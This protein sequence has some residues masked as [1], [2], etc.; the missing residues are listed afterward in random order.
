MRS[1]ILAG[2]AAM[3]LTAPA[4]AQPSKGNNGGSKGGGNAPAKVE[5]GSGGGQAQRAERQ[6][7]RGLERQEARA[8]RQ[9]DRAPKQR[10][11]RAARSK[12]IDRRHVREERREDRGQQQREVRVD[13]D[14]REGRDAVVR[15]QEARGQDRADFRRVDYDRR[16]ELFV[17]NAFR[18]TGLIDGCP[19]GLAAKNNGCLPP[20]QARKLIGNAVPATLGGALLPSLYRSWYPDNDDYFYRTEGDYVYRIDR[21]RNLVDG[22]F[23][24]Y[25]DYSGAYYVGAAYPQD[26]LGTYNVPVQYQPW[27]ADNGDDYYRYGDGAIYRVDRQGGLIEGIVS[28]LAGD[29]ALGQPLP[30]GYDAYN[31]PYAYRDRYADSDDALYR[32]NDGYIYQVD[33]TTR[34]VQTIVETLI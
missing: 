6:Q 29:L 16:D 28:L 34:L 5:R 27:Y 12:D 8:D 20:G 26:Y 18:S 24:L 9:Q 11:V 32:Y 21:D 30:S 10:D 13:R 17:S 14:R 23:P 3:A 19:P 22:F 4:L 15:V 7:V 1:I 31:V 2:V 33:P 25:D